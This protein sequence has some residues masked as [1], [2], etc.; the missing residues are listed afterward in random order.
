MERSGMAR[1]RGKSRGVGGGSHKSPSSYPARRQRVEFRGKHC[2]YLKRPE[3]RASPAKLLFSLPICVCS[4][5]CFR[6][7]LHCYFGIFDPIYLS[8]VKVDGMP[9]TSDRFMWNLFCSYLPKTKEAYSNICATQLFFCVWR[10]RGWGTKVDSDS[11]MKTK[12]VKV[13]CNLWKEV[14]KFGNS[15][16]DAFQLQLE[17]EMNRSNTISLLPSSFTY[18]L[19]R[20]FFRRKISTNVHGRM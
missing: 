13:Q 19:V 18:S 11:N 6:A 12:L 2:P 16:L 10:G 15:N 5:R 14:P 20:F 17:Q 1:S 7:I 9:L 8:S 4:C 3:A